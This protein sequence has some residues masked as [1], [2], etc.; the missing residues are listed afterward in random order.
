LDKI[1]EIFSLLHEDKTGTDIS[2]T[3]NIQTSTVGIHKAGLF[4]KLGVDNILKLRE[5][6]TTYNS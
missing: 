5:M 3:L 4:E 2:H 1:F 6:A